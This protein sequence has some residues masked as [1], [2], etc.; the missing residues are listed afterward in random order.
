M[1]GGVGKT[2]IVAFLSQAFASLGKKVL[3]IDMDPNNNLTDYFLRET[4]IDEI[5]SK[6]IRH[7]LTGRLEIPQA[8][9]TTT[10]EVDCIP[11]TPKLASINSELNN[12]FGSVLVF[13]KS[14]RDLKYDFILLDSPPAD[15][16]E[17]R[18]CLYVSDIVICPISYSRWTLQGYEILEDMIGINRKS[19]KKTKSICVP[20]NVSPKKSEGI[21]EIGNDIPVS[22]TH[23]SR[24]EGLENA[25]TLGTKIKT[26]SIAWNQFIDLAKELSK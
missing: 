14:L 15:C 6:N 20:S 21:L 19:G 3:I 25:V 2:T 13:E 18:T 1:K 17:L 26:N 22:E 11:A 5:S 12:D 24:N 4:L 23:I 16:F 9:Y 10:F 8:I 7:V